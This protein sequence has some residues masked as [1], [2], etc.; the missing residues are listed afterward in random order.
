[1][2]TEERDVNRA[3]RPLGPAVPTLLF[4]VAALAS[5]A[6]VA[7]DAARDGAEGAGG[8]GGE[9][10]VP[11]VTIPRAAIV[12]MTRA[13]TRVICTSEPFL[14][15]MGFEARV[16]LALAEEAID[17]C[18]MPLPPEIDPA[19]LDNAT[20]EACPRE[21]YAEAGYTEEKAR[22]CFDAAVEAAAAGAG[23][24]PGGS[25]PGPEPAAPSPSEPADGTGAAAE[26]EGG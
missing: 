10:A 17:R 24:E 20:L 11:A 8:G 2:D 22:P 12:D 21:V 23:A 26:D 4:A 6:A 9:R 3:R 15:C 19:G 14:S 16:C 13:Q 7:Q 1:M 5:A 18:L 25:S